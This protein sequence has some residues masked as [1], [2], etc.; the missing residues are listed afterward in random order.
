ML[1]KIIMTTVTAAL[2]TTAA[3]AE[4]KWE[5]TNLEQ[6]ESAV[7]DAKRDQVIVSNISGHPFE[8]DG[9]G[10]LSLIAASG[11]VKNLNWVEG[12]NAPKG[13]A[14]MGDKVFVSD[15]TQLHIIDLETG[16]LEQSL[17]AEGAVFLNDVAASDDTVWISDMMTHTIWVYK[18][19]T[20][21]PFLTDATNL[22]HPNGL[23]FDGDRLVVGTWGVGM[24]DDF[25]TDTLGSLVSV[26]LES[27]AIT[28]IAGAE[29]IGNLDGVIR[30]DDTFVV[31]DWING[32]VFAVAPN[33]PAKEV[34]QYPQ[35]LA[36]IASNG[37][38]VY[39]PM[40]MDGKM[41]V[42]DGTAWLK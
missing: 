12:L 26:D 39:M 4:T 21:S 5:V 7:F 41:F 38:D 15:L 27:K 31:N 2:L 35:G 28:P 33:E 17:T 19:G 14:I 6:P 32:K 3:Y 37:T 13:L 42:V 30:I 40:M 18:D 29:N 25:S 20:L 11:E 9:K 8:A 1:Q 34:A 16:A 24:K 22:S 36:D 23:F 10:F